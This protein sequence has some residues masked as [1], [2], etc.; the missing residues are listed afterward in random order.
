MKKEFFRYISFL[1]PF[2]VLSCSYYQPIKVENLKQQEKAK[3][4]QDFLG[5]VV[6]KGDIKLT[7]NVQSFK[8]KAYTN[9]ILPK[10]TSDI[11]SFKFFLTNNFNDPL[12]NMV[13]PIIWFDFDPANTTLII[14]DVPDG[15]NYYGV[16]SA[17]DD[18]ANST[19]AN[20]I[21]E[22][23]NT[24]QSIDKKWSRTTNTVSLINGFDI[25][26]D[27]SGTLKISMPIKFGVP[28]STDV[29]IQLLPGNPITPG[30]EQIQ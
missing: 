6:K 28:A 17:Y 29:G 1:L 24:I 8:T 13:T 22:P 12:N 9:A 15:N 18:I 23:D 3:V 14:K 16:I 4:T 30:G 21:T 5:K 25:Y 10:K 2:L 27:N 19:S 7:I 11:K 26:S 20:N